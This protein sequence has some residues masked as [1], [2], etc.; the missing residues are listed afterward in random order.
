MSWKKHLQTVTMSTKL[1]R[2]QSNSDYGPV[3]NSAMSGK[4]SS[5]LPEVY[6]GNPQRIERYVQYDNMDIDSEVN[7]ALDTIAEFS[8][9]PNEDNN[10]LFEL[11]FSETPNES[12]M[13]VITRLLDQWI[14]MNGFKKKLFRL[15]R[16]TLKYGDQIFIRDPSTMKLYWIDMY[17][18]ESVIVDEANG[19][20]PVSYY[21]RDLDLNLQTA[22]ATIPTHYGSNVMGNGFRPTMQNGGYDVNNTNGN[23]GLQPAT[24]NSM[25]VASQAIPV[26]AAHVVHFS[27]SEGLDANWPFGTSVLESIFKVY[28][29]KEL[30]EDSIVIYRV[31]RA[32]ERRAFYIDVGDMKLTKAGAYLEKIKMEIHQKRMPS[33]TGGGANITDARYDP[34]SILDDYFFATNSDGRGSRVEILPGGENLGSIDDLKYFNNKMVRG[35]RVPSSYLPTGPEDSQAVYTDGRVGT[36]YIQEY[37]FSN[38]CQR[39]QNVLTDTFD[40]EFKLYIKQRGYDNIDVSIFELILNPPQNFRKFAQIERDAAMISSFQALADTPY[41][42]K[43]FLLSRYLGLSD[44]EII[45]NETLWKEENAD[46][47]HKLGEPSTSEGDIGL[48]SVGIRNTPTDFDSED[49]NISDDEMEFDDA[50]LDAEGGDEM[51][52]EE[53]IDLGEE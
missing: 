16:N 20:E 53:P 33:R 52:S 31:Q 41:L 2:Q 13:T 47:N 42:A 51:T 27:L 18:V 50:D 14:K 15:F 43:R 45:E 32:P 38:Y 36:A 26:D 34:L 21:I 24:V 40:Q 28:K 44:E 39:I 10:R 17:K 8:T 7:A 35:L 1:S 48:D 3:T 49:L 37:R 22:V 12:E 29:Q 4:Y 46:T 9:R 5:Y 25:N 19:K 11:N 23:S 30:L 6:A